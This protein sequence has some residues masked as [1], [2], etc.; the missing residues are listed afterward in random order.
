MFLAFVGKRIFI[1]SSNTKESGFTT[2]NAKELHITIGYDSDESVLILY[3]DEK[4][5]VHFIDDDG[6]HKFSHCDID[7]LEHLLF[8]NGSSDH[9]PT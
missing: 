7:I 3:K 1:L 5:V 9:E 8:S 6:S 2:G 4:F